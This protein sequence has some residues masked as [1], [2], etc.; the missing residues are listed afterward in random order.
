MARIRLRTRLLVS[1]VL[2]FAGLTVATVYVARR[3]VEQ[4]VRR[5]IVQDLHN[6]VSTFQNVEQQRAESLTHSAELMANLPI[7]KAIM[8]TGH[9]ETI[10]DASRELFTLAEADLFVL[11]DRTGRIVALHSPTGRFSRESAQASLIRSFVS[12]KDS[13]WW[14][15]DDRLFE[16]SV[17]PIYFGP[18]NGDRSL[19]FVVVGDEI[20]DDS[21]QQLRQVAAAQVTFLFGNKVLRSS[22]SPEQAA[23]L[24]SLTQSV[25][26]NGLQP[27]EIQLGKERFLGTAV[28]L[29]PGVTPGVQLSV[30]KSLDQA[31]AFLDNLNRLLYTLGFI[32]LAV[33]GALVF[34]SSH[35]L[36]RPLGNLVDA[37]RAL[38]RGDYRYPVVVTSTDEVAEV[39]ASFLHMRSNLQETQR[40]LLDAERLATIGQ[41]AS[42]ISHD[43]RHSLAAILANAEFLSESSRSD[44]E[45]AELYQEVRAAVNQM[46]DLIDSLLEFSRTRESLRPSF[47]DL[48]DV[49]ARAIENVQ[50]HPEFATVPVQL[51][52][53]GDT[54]GW[55]DSR[56]LER[57]FQNLLV[58]ACEAAPRGSGRIL[59]RLQST[60]RALDI[61]VTDNGHGILDPVRDR[62][63]DPFVSYGKENGTGLGLT[64]VHKIVQDHAGSITIERTGPDGTTFLITLPRS[65]PT[66]RPA[67]S[68]IATPHFQP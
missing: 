30:L 18:Q 51:Q 56:K 67:E 36:T 45:R 23:Q 62:L 13:H 68:T 53:E 35:T 15:G 12:V 9:A 50:R 54:E 4:Q 14:I 11:A 20:D 60:P 32:A 31:T 39:T 8:T 44:P 47:C 43:L 34:L 38:G 1:L 27:Q 46:T 16:V 64:V 66:P 37:V 17:Q 58:N 33:G 59:V 7:V 42:S 65:A 10:Q 41:M 24:T 57:V 55:F 52:I 63:F 21:V 25:S 26:T 61:R 19:G 48:Q 3:T 5:Q 28:S 49:L 40:R 6:S 22:L 29:D 2:V